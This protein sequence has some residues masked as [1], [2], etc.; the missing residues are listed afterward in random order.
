MQENCVTLA[1]SKSKVFSGFKRS[2][3]SNNFQRIVHKYIRLIAEELH[4][5]IL[6]IDRVL[7]LFVKLSLSAS[8]DRNSKR[9]P[10]NP[11]V[12]LAASRVGCL[13]HSSWL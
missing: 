13:S 5:G 8:T 2:F 10:I 6:G 9:F 4:E 7:T 3:Y 11:L 1:R 12:H